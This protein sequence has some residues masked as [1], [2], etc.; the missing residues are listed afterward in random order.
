MRAKA[1]FEPR[2][3]GMAALFHHGSLEFGSAE[4]ERIGEICAIVP[5]VVD[6]YL[7]RPAVITPLVGPAGAI[8][9]N[10]GVTEAALLDV[11]FGATSPRG[12]LPFDLPR[13]D[14]AVAAS[15]TDVPFDTVD[16]LFRFGHGLRY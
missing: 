15:R 13:S 14:R 3:E 10:F 12:R 9:A 5:T 2:S 11:L 8:V 6:V 1:P 4:L 7:D 16:P